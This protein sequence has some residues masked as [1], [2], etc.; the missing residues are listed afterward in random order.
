MPSELRRIM[1][2]GKGTRAKR[3][4]VCVL[5]VLLWPILLI[6]RMFWPRRSL[7]T[8][9]DAPRILLIR[10]D[11][12]G[13]LTMSATIFPGLRRRFPGGKVDLLTSEVATPIGQLLLKANWIDSLFTLPLLHRTLGDH[14]RMAKQFRARKYDVA[15]D[16]RSDV[17]NVLLIWL[18]GAPIRLGLAGSGLNYLLT[19]SLDLPLKR[20]QADEP[21]ALVKRLG[22]EELDRWP[23]LPLGDDDLAAADQWLVEHKLTRDRPICAFHLGAFLPSKVWPLERFIAVARRLRD[24]INAQLL[25]VGGKSEIDLAEEFSKQ[26]GGEVAIATAATSLPL[27]AAILSR[28]CVLVGNDSGPAHVAAAVG[29]PVV[30]LFGNGNPSHFGVRSE[31]AILMQSPHPCSPGCGKECARP[32]TRCMLDLSVDAVSEAARSL[33]LRTASPGVPCEE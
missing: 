27:T 25:V 2:V 24:E 20:H 4:V 9:P 17:R 10:I 28:A 3:I 31:N 29:C 26:L 22:V 30:V 15:I 19:E 18:S 23:R 1:Q 13:D 7:N 21:E 16:L 32:A 11:G 14:L 8:V 6:P 12:I 33:A 5:H